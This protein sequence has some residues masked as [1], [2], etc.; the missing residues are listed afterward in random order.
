MVLFVHSASGWQGPKQTAINFSIELLPREK[1]LKK[2]LRTS[3]HET[4]NQWVGVYTLDSIGCGPRLHQAN[5]KLRFSSCY[6]VFRSVCNFNDY[7]SATCSGLVRF[8]QY[9]ATSFQCY[10]TDIQ[11]ENKRSIFGFRKRPFVFC[12]AFKG[13]ALACMGPSWACGSTRACPSP[14]VTF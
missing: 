8:P 14:S 1:H 9:F 5:L 7:E 4:Y 6:F 11:N 2:H 3:K 12:E 13:W 10:Q